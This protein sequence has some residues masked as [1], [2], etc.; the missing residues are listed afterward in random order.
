MY[1]VADPKNLAYGWETE[2]QAQCTGLLIL[3][4]TLND[5][6]DVKRACLKWKLRF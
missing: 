4:P 2:G 6:R 1:K 5:K 3:V